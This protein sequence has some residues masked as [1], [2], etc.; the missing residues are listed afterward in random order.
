MF[1]E[2]IENV[3][4]PMTIGHEQGTLA[5]PDDINFRPGQYSFHPLLNGEIV[6]ALPVESRRDVSGAVCQVFTRQVWTGSPVPIELDR[7][8]PSGVVWYHHVSLE[9]TLETRETTEWPNGR[10][11]LTIALCGPSGAS[12]KVTDESTEVTRQV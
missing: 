8:S 10:K 12:T 2:I 9:L 6:L 4:Y 1:E 7:E 11:Y 5:V 3:Y